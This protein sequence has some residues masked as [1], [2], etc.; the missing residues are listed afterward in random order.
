[1]REV[2]PQYM[3]YSLVTEGGLVISGMISNESVN[4][5]TI[6]KPDGTE[7]TILRINIDEL[8]SSGLSF[9]PEGLEKQVDEQAMAHLI[10]YLMSQKS[11]K[12]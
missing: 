2:K 3:N 12:K 1:N 8:R 11:A 5:I 10:S 6:R 4:S 7:S 9:M